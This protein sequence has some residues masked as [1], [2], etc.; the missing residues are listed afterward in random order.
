MG[1]HH[2]PSSA[3]S[4]LQILRRQT[5]TAQEI[6]QEAEPMKALALVAAVEFGQKLQSQQTQA[7]E[8]V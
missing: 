1:W 5:L 2:C 7:L 6:D 3:I 4:S 8:P